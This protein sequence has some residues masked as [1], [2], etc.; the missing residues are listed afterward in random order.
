[1]AAATN[2]F[3]AC[4]SGMLFR[5]FLRAASESLEQGRTK[6]W[7]VLFLTQSV[8]TFH[9]NKP[10]MFSTSLH[11][12]YYCDD[13]EET[14]PVTVLVQSVAVGNKTELGTGVILPTR[15]T[16]LKKRALRSWASPYNQT[17]LERQSFFFAAYSKMKILPLVS[18]VFPLF[19]SHTVSAVSNATAGLL[20]SRESMNPICY[21]EGAACWQLCNSCFR[22]VVRSLW[23]CE[24]IRK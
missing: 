20:S 24:N 3:R 16:E 11:H 9:T 5:V 21:S 22:R 19:I 1:M 23:A 2:V 7:R 14:M 12:T 4:S 13:W 15:T 18:V 8:T 10:P 6:A 17:L